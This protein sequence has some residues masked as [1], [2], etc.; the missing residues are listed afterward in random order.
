MK[1]KI[2][3]VLFL[4][5]FS[6]S[7]KLSAQY[8]RTDLVSAWEF[9]ETSGLTAIDAF[10]YNDGDLHSS[11]YPN[12]VGKIN[13]AYS[14]TNG[15]VDIGD[16][17]YSPITLSC[18]IKINQTGDAYL[19]H[20]FAKIYLAIVNGKVRWNVYDGTSNGTFA[21]STTTLSPGVWYHVVVTWNGI[22]TTKVY[23]NGNLQGTG[24]SNSNYYGDDGSKDYTYI[25]RR[26]D[27]STGYFNGLIDQPAM[28][29]RELSASEI[30]ELNNNNS[31]LPF[32][33]WSSPPPPPEL[34][35][36]INPV[37]KTI[38]HNTEPGQIT[39]TAAGGN[40]PYTYIWQQS[41]NGTYFESIED[42][43][44]NTYTPPALTQSTWFKCIVLSY[45]DDGN[46][47]KIC[48]VTV[49]PP[50]TSGNITSDKT[51]YS[52]ESPGLISVSPNGGTG[53]YTYQW[54][55]STDGNNFT[56][57]QG[58][59]SNPFTAPT[60]CQNTWYKC[61]VGDGTGTV[62]SDACAVTVI[63][64][65]VTS[66]N[67]MNGDVQLQLSFNNNDLSITEGNTVTLP[68]G[69]SNITGIL[70]GIGLSGGGTTGDI[71][72]SANSDDGIWNANKLQNNPV[73]S[74]TPLPGQVLKWDGMFWTPSDNG[75]WMQ[76][77]NGIYNINQGNIGI[78]TTPQ[79]DKSLTVNGTVFSKE[80]IV[81]LQ[82]P[83]PDYVFD[84]HYE[85]R[86]TSELEEFIKKYNHL[87]EFPPAKEMEANGIS[88]AD[89]NMLL[90]KKI[91]ELTLYIIEQENRIKKLESLALPQ[92][93]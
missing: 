57:I 31:G 26:T 81:D 17:V 28:W 52:C 70:P 91:E 25:G 93:Q 19:F 75:Y 1:I 66:V 79:A 87:P 27:L 47:E 62:S 14:F 44:S 72:L 36:T 29:Y 53:S 86:S 84:E 46:V 3:G 83:A 88:L 61:E 18:W 64:K 55:N 76:N 43:N 85:L 33:Q 80:I 90:L 23:L 59:E 50:L 22:N 68:Y 16:L 92:K 6:F 54:M 74:I 15:W 49:I 11:V 24:S 40:Q 30:S 67:T 12:A 39:V 77:G 58:A 34:S 45:G 71:T 10:S 37:N 89:L 63:Q 73:S 20:H 56:D 7:S 4:L 9:D 69:T 82:V 2:F 78:G 35:A 32:D 8:L 13:K 48:A 42:E 38:S 5:T 51:I 41:T 60:L 21:W 65:E